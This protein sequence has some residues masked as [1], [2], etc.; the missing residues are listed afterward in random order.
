M[1]HRLGPP[2][3]EGHVEGDQ[4][5]RRLQVPRHRTA[6]HPPAPGVEHDRQIEEAGQVGTYVMSATQSSSG[7]EAEKSRSTRSSAALDFAARFVVFPFPASAHAFD[8]RRPHP[9]GD[10]VHAHRTAPSPKLGVDPRCAVRPAAHGVDLGDRSAERRVLARLSRRLAAAPR[11]VPARG[12]TQQGGTSH[13]PDTR[14]GD[15]SRTGTP[16]GIDPLSLAGHRRAAVVGPWFY[17]SR[18]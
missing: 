5:Q 11:I 8:L 13:A 7:P 15:R 12:K 16:P 1:D 10:A 2:L 4:H 9:P 17:F 14:P 18:Q 3:R 6:H